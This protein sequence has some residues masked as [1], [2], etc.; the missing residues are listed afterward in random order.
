MNDTKKLVY[1]NGYGDAVTVRLSDK[2]I[3]VQLG[4]EFE[5]NE[6]D[7]K[8]LTELAAFELVKA[9]SETDEDYFTM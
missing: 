5:A 8:G 3:T 1:V 9:N 6:E 4:E 2:E 7:A